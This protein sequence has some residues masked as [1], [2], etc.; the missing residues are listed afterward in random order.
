MNTSPPW[1]ASILPRIPLSRTGIP[2]LPPQSLDVAES[3]SRLHIVS[4]TSLHLLSSPPPISSQCYPV[5]L[6]LDGLMANSFS[7]SS[8]AT[9]QGSARRSRLGIR[10]YR[11][12]QITGLL[13]P[14]KCWKEIVA[15]L[16]DSSGEEVGSAALEHP[17]GTSTIQQI[18]ICAR[19]SQLPA[20]S[21]LNM[22]ARNGARHL[23]FREDAVSLP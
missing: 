16:P 18:H 2:Q 14:D 22:P 3:F 4:N 23:C 1:T 5:L 13:H 9:F 20:A 19:R 17:H 21:K 6:V 8:R 10:V 15:R 11:N 7:S 12:S